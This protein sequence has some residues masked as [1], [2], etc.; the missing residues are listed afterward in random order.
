M[1]VSWRIVSDLGYVLR[2]AAAT[3]AAFY[4]DRHLTGEEL[5]ALQSK[6]GHRTGEQAVSPVLADEMQHANT[7][8]KH[9]SFGSSRAMSLAGLFAL[10]LL[11]HA[12]P[13]GGG[14]RQHLTVFNGAAFDAAIDSCIALSTSNGYGVGV[15][16]R[17]DL[18]PESK[19]QS[20]TC[21][22]GESVNAKVAERMRDMLL[23]RL[24]LT[25]DV[26]RGLHLPDVSSSTADQDL[27]IDET[28]RCADA[29]KS[30][31]DSSP[32]WR[33]CSH[34]GW[35]EKV[36]VVFDEAQLLF[37]NRRYEA[38]RLWFQEATMRLAAY[39]KKTE[40]NTVLHFTCFTSTKV[41]ILTQTTP[42]GFRGGEKAGGLTKSGRRW[43]W[44]LYF[45][46]ASVA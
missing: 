19:V 22:P 44:M 46:L 9:Y 40:P 25:G 42:R 30:A 33:K 5:S 32:S 4:V 45:F 12:A 3:S 15:Q 24:G 6:L 36:R 38:A 8:M 26:R 37:R 1:E 7:G 23:Q 10:Q 21:M 41:Q 17:L 43:Y 29:L 31:T 11:G 20:S 34:R 27:L 16:S 14:G 18:L 39:S 35:L 28:D 2:A 13:P